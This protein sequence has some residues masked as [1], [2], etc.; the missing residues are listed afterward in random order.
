MET[1]KRVIVNYRKQIKSVNSNIHP[2]DYWSKEGEAMRLVEKLNRMNERVGEKEREIE[3][4]GR[5]F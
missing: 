1:L 3:E 5:R 4:Q 2:M